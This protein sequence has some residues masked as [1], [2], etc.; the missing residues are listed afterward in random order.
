MKMGVNSQKRIEAQIALLRAEQ[1]MARS[2]R[3]WERAAAMSTSIDAKLDE[4]VAQ[5][6]R[7]I[8]DDVWEMVRTWDGK[9]SL[10]DWSNLFWGEVA[11]G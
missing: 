1:I 5:Y 2:K 4:Y 9:G 7:A 3:Q 8:Q 6:R 11:H 10:A